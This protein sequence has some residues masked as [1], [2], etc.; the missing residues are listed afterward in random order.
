MHLVV[1][2]ETHRSIRALVRVPHLV[3]LGLG[4]GVGVGEGL[5]VGVGVGR[6]RG[7]WLVLGQRF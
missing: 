7:I 2:V 4:V 6:G 5:G 1:L 3:G